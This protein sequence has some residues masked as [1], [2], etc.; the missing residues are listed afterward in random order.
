[1]DL[2]FIVKKNKG[3][4]AYENQTTSGIISIT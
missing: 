3:I 1:M 2:N 4:Y